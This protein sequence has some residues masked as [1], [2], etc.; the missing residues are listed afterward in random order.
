MPR[1]LDLFCGGGGAAEGYIRAGFTVIGVDKEERHRTC[2][3]SP[4]VCQDAFAYLLT[5]HHEFDVVHASPPCQ[6]YSTAVTSF[7]DGAGIDTPKLIPRLRDILRRLNKPY[8]IENVTGAREELEHPIVLCGSM[9]GL[10]ITRHRYFETSH[11]VPQPAHPPCLGRTAAFARAMGWSMRECYIGGH[12]QNA[13]IGDKWK[14]LL[15]V[16]HHMTLRELSESIPP[17]YTEYIGS[18]F[19]RMFQPLPS[20]F[21]TK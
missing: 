14:L 12:G 20:F 9:F 7:K 3:P 8:I 17:A 10:H 15:D 2:Y 5:H 13:G 18:H 6:G 11:A 1:L 19:I 4:F 16:R 21:K